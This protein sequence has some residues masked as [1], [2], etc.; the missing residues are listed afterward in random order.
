M[1]ARSGESPASHSELAAALERDG[2]LAEAAACYERALALDPGLSRAH[3]QLGNLFIQQKNIDE[4]IGC[5]RRALALT[6]DYGGAHNNLANALSE[7]GKLNEAISHYRQAVALKADSPDVHYNLGNALVRQG[8][9]DEGARHYIQAL[10]LRPRFAAAQYSLATIFSRHGHLDMAIAGCRRA[11]ELEPDFVE[12]F[13][14][15]VML[16]MQACDWRTAEE[17][18]RR[19][20]SLM[21]QYPGRISPANL[22]CQTS[23]AAEQ[24]QCA[25]D[26][27]RKLKTGRRRDLR[28]SRPTSRARLRLGYLCADYHDHP[29]AQLV[30]DMI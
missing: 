13:A 9:L 29:L 11:V 17:D 15:L 14:Q 19:I 30:V 23:T 6:P 22:L 25:R 2:R 1:A 7:Q 8:R 27:A 12:A 3:F 21:R 26:W 28:H 10:A 24:F 18:E 4:A 20:L 5:Y 16:N